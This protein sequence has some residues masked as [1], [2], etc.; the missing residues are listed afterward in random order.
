[1]WREF[2]VKVAG[3]WVCVSACVFDG[4]FDVGTGRDRVARGG[5]AEL[6]LMLV[7]D[8]WAMTREVLRLNLGRMWFGLQIVVGVVCRI[9]RECFD[10]MGIR[11]LM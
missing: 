3:V 10:G 9:A 5:L 6:M 11:I 7:G 8:E 1:M 2:V 4:C